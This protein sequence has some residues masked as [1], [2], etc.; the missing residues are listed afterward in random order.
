MKVW[1]VM[2]TDTGGGASYVDDIFDDEDK[3]NAH[4]N[5]LGWPQE[6]VKWEVS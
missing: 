5:K 4:Q 1:V 6:V 2:I 3:A